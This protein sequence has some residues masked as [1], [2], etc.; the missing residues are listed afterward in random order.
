MEEKRQTARCPVCQ[1]PAKTEDSGKIT[2]RRSTCTHN[3][4]HVRCPRCGSSSLD[5]VQFAHNTYTYTCA[6]CTGTFQRPR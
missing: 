2:C 6:E 5:S 1:G 4:A 3:H